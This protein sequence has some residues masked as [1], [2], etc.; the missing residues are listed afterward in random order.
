MMFLPL[1]VV[2][3]CH[4]MIHSLVLHDGAMTSISIFPTSDAGPDM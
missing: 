4:R 2:G 1:D 3:L